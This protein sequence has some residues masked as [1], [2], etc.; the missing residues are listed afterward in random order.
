MVVVRGGKRKFRT[1]KNPNLQRLVHNLAIRI[2]SSE[3]SQ[4]ADKKCPKN[5]TSNSVPATA[6]KSPNAPAKQPPAASSAVA[7]SSTPSDPDADA[8]MNNIAIMAAVDMSG[9]Y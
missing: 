1:Q 5:N 3:M 9:C 6:A 2:Q 4:P 7:S 8:M